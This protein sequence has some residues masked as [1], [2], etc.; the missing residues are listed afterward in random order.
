MATVNLSWTIPVSTSDIVNVV[1]FKWN[2]LLTDTS[3]LE[4]SVSDYYSSGSSATATEVAVLAPTVSIYT[5]SSATTGNWTYAC[6]AKN[7]AGV[8]LEANGH[9]N[10]TVT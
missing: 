10:L 9:D 5:D 2:D 3:A 8:K 4:T 7:S 1:V 6:C